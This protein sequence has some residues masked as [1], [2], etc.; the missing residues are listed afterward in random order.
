M[1]P[2][3]TYYQRVGDTFALYL[4]QGIAGTNTGWVDSGFGAST[5]GIG[6]VLEVHAAPAVPEDTSIPFPVVRYTNESHNNIFA[7]G[8]WSP[9]AAD[10][11]SSLGNL[12]A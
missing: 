3:Q 11:V 2:F 5:G 12:K 10:Y 6:A 4:F 9:T 8:Y 1:V 7:L